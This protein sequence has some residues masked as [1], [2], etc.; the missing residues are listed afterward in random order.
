LESHPVEVLAV[1]TDALN[2]EHMADGITHY[3]GQIEFEHGIPATPVHPCRCR[4]SALGH[5]AALCW[6]PGAVAFSTPG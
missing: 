2:A 6:S 4:S 5:I 1:D 3:G